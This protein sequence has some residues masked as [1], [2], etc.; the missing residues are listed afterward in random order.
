MLQAFRKM[1]EEQGRV[2]G[3][4]RGCVWVETVRQSS[5]ASCS[6]RNGCGQH[7]SEKYKPDASLSYINAVSAIVLKKG[8]RV[9]VG[10]PEGSLLKASFL[11]YLFPLLLMMS[12][13]WL[14]SL[15]VVADWVLALVAGILLLS[16][17]SLVRVVGKRSADMC[18]VE[19]I[20]KL[21]SKEWG[22]S[23]LS[24]ERNSSLGQF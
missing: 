14:L 22:F 1:I 5:C 2:V 3:V 12:G 20:R 7:L 17:F 24:S 21:P 8:D 23:E 15:L 18:R 9:I 11:L 19:V 16:G 4:E 13:V 6:A 10:I